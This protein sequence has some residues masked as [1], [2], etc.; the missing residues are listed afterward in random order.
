MKVRRSKDEL[1]RD[2][3]LVREA[4]Q[5]FK[6]KT[7]QN[8]ECLFYTGAIRPNGYGAFSLGGNK[9]GNTVQAHRYAYTLSK[10]SI[11][12]GMIIMHSCDNPACVNPDHLMAGTLSENSMDRDS[13]RRTPMA[14][15]TD[16][17]VQSV[18]RLKGVEPRLVAAA[19]NI[20]KQHVGAIQSRK[21]WKQVEE[22]V[23]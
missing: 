21:A 18:R 12:H 5:R 15:L 16:R 4:A 8:G 23:L 9:T 19:F 13:K 2:H 17:Q 3:E 14:R 6:M 20:T 1:L 22:V 11:P 10:G 7:R